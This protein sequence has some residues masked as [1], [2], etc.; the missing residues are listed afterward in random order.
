[1]SE[2][3]D[4]GDVNRFTFYDHSK[5][6]FASPPEVLRVNE[7]H[8]REYDIMNCVGF[9]TRHIYPT[10]HHPISARAQ[11]LTP[12]PGEMVLCCPRDGDARTHQRP[13]ATP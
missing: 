4:L 6:L 12:Q 11:A 2:I 3:R 9:I 10:S 13:P 5:A 7:K 8:I 1:M